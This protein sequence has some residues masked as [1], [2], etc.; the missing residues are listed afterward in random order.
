MLEE[1]NHVKDYNSKAQF[2]RHSE[3]TKQSI[4]CF[5]DPVH[6]TQKIRHTVMQIQTSV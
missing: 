1:C 5:E 2:E 4:F 3:G 6:K